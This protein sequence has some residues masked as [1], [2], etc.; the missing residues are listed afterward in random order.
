M[1]YYKVEKDGIR[2]PLSNIKNIGIVTC[3]DI[4][5]NRGTGFT[6]IFDCISK[7]TTRNVS[8]KTLEVLILASC[9]DSFGYNK[10]TLLTNLDKL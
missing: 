1:G 2:Y 7:I 4:I 5:N 6:D 9:F 10:K 8:E 3:R